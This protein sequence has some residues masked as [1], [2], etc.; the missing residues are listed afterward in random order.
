MTEKEL[1]NILA[2]MYNNALKGESVSMIHMF[3]IKYADEIKKHGVKEIIERS[4]LNS[5]YATEVSKGMKLAKYVVA[6]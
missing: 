2:D 6:K 3:G 1:S 5:S 4:G